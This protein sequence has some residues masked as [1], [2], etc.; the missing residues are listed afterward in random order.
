MDAAL[1]VDGEGAVAGDLHRRVAVAIRSAILGEDH[2]QTKYL[3]GVLTTM[4]DSEIPA[5]E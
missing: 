2:D 1:D 5:N 4:L 3:A